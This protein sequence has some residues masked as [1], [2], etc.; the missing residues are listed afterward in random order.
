MSCSEIRTTLALYEGRE[1]IG[2]IV[3]ADRDWRA[4]D[5]RGNVLTGSPFKSQKA[6]AAAL[7]ASRPHLCIADARLDNGVGHDVEAIHLR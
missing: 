1:P 5:V 6:A 4:V 7:N 3:G 2:S